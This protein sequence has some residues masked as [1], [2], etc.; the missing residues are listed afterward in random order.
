[1]ARNTT[2]AAESPEAEATWTTEVDD[3]GE[4]Y[5]A[6]SEDAL[7]REA[8]SAATARIRESHKDEFRGLVQEEAAKRGVTYEF[9]KSAE[10]KAAEQLAD[11]LAKFPDLAT[12]VGQA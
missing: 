4:G 6:K 7:K 12:K 3:P 2:A 5:V 11:L 10:E 9:R 1:M 8:Y